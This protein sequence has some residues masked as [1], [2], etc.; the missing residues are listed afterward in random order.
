[1]S[2]LAPSDMVATACLFLNRQ[3]HPETLVAAHPQNKNAVKSGVFSQNVLASRVEE[4]DGEIASRAPAEVLTD[5]LRREVAGL[6]ALAEAMDQS[7]EDDGLR[8]RNDEPRTLISLRLRVNERLRRTLADYSDAASPDSL[9]LTLEADVGAGSGDEERQSETLPHAIAKNHLRESIAGL[10]PR[11]LDPEVFLRSIV[12][13]EDPS[14]QFRHIKRARKMLTKYR[15]RRSP[16][17][18]CFATLVSRDELELQTWVEDL[19]AAGYE[20]MRADPR[21]ATF[22][23]HFSRGGT[24]D[25]RAAHRHTQTAVEDVVREG[26]ERVQGS[27]AQ[28]K[29]RDTG[30]S[31]PAIGRFW[32][33]LLSR[34]AKTSVDERLD[35]LEA[36]DEWGVLPQCTCKPPPKFELEEELADRH[37]AYVIRAVARKHYRAATMIARFPETHVAV[38]DAID[39]AAL[40]AD[41]LE[42]DL[43]S[44]S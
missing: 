37:R 19:R 15:S 35:A 11:D 8:G 41:L 38:R 10:Q 42:P 24:L 29:H 26:V 22:V 12:I 32:K 6:T 4:L 31:D 16:L 28:G 9:P 17:C 23:R 21:V 34:S 36:L 27:Q 7:L 2:E 1:M 44:A 3:G 5:V 30:E 14:V 43:G 13:A 25:P 33:I 18:V 39:N 20:P 40:K